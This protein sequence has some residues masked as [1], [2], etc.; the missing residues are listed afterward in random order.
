MLLF[1]PRVLLNPRP[2]AVSPEY[3]VGYRRPLHVALPLPA[4]YLQRRKVPLHEH[5]AGV[6]AKAAH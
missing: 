4:P 5:P 1:P 3:D 2:V 6:N